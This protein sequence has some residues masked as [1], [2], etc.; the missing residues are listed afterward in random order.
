MEDDLNPHIIK[1]QHPVDGGTRNPTITVAKSNKSL[2]ERCYKTLKKWTAIEEGEVDVT[3]LDFT[4]DSWC[5]RKHRVGKKSKCSQAVLLY[6]KHVLC[7]VFDFC[8]FVF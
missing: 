7:F 8:I 4:V 5:T 6:I 1:I 2:R 3:E